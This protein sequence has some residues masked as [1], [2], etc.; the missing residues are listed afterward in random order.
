[1]GHPLERSDFKGRQHVEPSM[2]SRFRV[3]ERAAFQ[4]D[5]PFVATLIAPAPAGTLEVAEYA[6]LAEFKAEHDPED[7]G[8]VCS[9]L[10]A[11]AFRPAPGTTLN[12]APRLRFVRAGAGENVPVA[13][14]IDWEDAGGD[15][16]AIVITAIGKG[17]YTNGLWVKRETNPALTGGKDLTVG[18][19]SDP[20]WTKTGRNL[21]LLFTLKYTGTPSGG[22]TVNIDDAGGGFVTTVSTAWPAG[23][24]A[25]A[26]TLAD[27][28]SVQAL[29]NW[30]NRQPGYQATV[31]DTDADLSRI[32]ATSINA[33]DAGEG[34]IDG[35]NAVRLVSFRGAV[36]QWVNDNCS[37]IGP[38]PG[39]TASSADPTVRAQ[40]NSGGNLIPKNYLSGGEDPTVDQTDYDAALEALDLAEV[41]S[42]ILF[43][44]AQA[45]TA[46]DTA[47]R[48]A[49]MT[50]MDE[51]DALGRMWRASFSLQDGAGVVTD[52]V[53]V[54]VAGTVDRTRV[55][56]L[57]CQRI[58]DINNPAVT[59]APAMVAAAFAGATAGMTPGTDIQSLVLTKERVKAGGIY[60]AD[61]RSKSAREKMIKAGLNMLREE[62]GQVLYSLAISTTQGST[63]DDNNRLRMMWSESVAVDILQR[64]IEDA[65]RPLGVAWA[66]DDYVARVKKAVRVQL[67]GWKAAG[68]ITDGIDPETGA[69][70]P[71]YSVPLVVVEDGVVT[72]SFSVGI[73]GEVDHVRIDGL[74]AKVNLSSAA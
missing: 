66:T 21:G 20:R 6:S 33:L 24:S 23:H 54:R 68:L 17:S 3:Q 36:I 27:F 41:P 44:P 26:I 49:A 25:L 8:A 55:A 12:G 67:E 37:R 19:K 34:R 32:P 46:A 56:G 64:S 35:A 15:T 73:A 65:V 43:F 40:L 52:A 29:V 2:Q 57:F 30:I 14:H 48:D 18:Y 61:R 42:G 13:A 22:G 51:Q 38:V 4:G 50:W 39:V 62:R 28:S 53:A 31:S 59:H 60:A 58:V 7:T 16:D 71:A 69:E 63:A 70:V 45:N 9:K 1:M 72:V 5:N 74:V 10:A 47:L 11:F